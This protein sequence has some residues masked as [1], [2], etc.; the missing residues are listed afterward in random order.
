MSLTRRRFLALAGL[1]ICGPAIA[2]SA[3]KQVG[4][5]RLLSARGDRAGGYRV[6]GLGDHGDIRFDQPLPGRGHGVAVHPHGHQAVCVARR[7]GDF[8]LVLDLTSGELVALRETPAGR[9]FYGHG[10]FSADGAFFY[11]TENAIDSGA[12]CIGLWDVSNGYR[13]VGELPS[14]GVGP[15]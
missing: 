10:V 6:S 3:P 8:M 7:P 4:A 11:T 1:S 12:G 2:E 14:H 5:I 15:H 9:H 13:P